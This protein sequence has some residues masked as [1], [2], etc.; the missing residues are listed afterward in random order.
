MVLLAAAGNAKVL[1]YVTRGTGVV[2]LLAPDR[3]NRPRRGDPDA[4]GGSAPTALHRLRAPPQHHAARS[5]IRGRPRRHHRRGPFRADRLQ[6]CRPAVPLA[7][8]A[9][10]ARARCR[11][12]RSAARTD[13]DELAARPDR[14]AC[15]ARGAL[16]RVRVVAGRARAFARH[17]QRRASRLDGALGIGCCGSGRGR[18]ALASRRCRR[19]RAV[20][21]PP[22]QPPPCR[23]PR[24]SRVGDAQDRF[25]PDGPRGPER[26]NRSSAS[27]H[28]HPPPRAQE[29]ARPSST[30]VQPIRCRRARSTRP[31]RAA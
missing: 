29:A 27:Q 28:A 9:G 18:G 15:V 23:A 11:C 17:R 16:A 4:L 19:S 13:R 26:R 8:Q 24:D 2:A 12:F 7:L 10:L 5:R 20:A 25:E 31:S 22:P 3:R 21:G 30:V 6:G 1:W 14:P